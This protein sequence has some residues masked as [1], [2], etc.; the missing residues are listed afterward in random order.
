MP[1]HPRQPEAPRNTFCGQTRRE[2]LWD[3]GGAFTSVALA[4]LL[5]SDGFL[6]GQA[7]AADGTTPLANPLQARPA[8]LPGRAKSVIFLFMYGGPS[9]VDTFDYKPKLYGLDGR[10]I[11]IRT[12]GRGGEKTQGRVVGPK[13]NF[14]PGANA[15]RWSR[16]SSRTSA[17]AWTTSPSSIPCTRSPRC[18][19]RRC[20]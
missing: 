4:G 15:A 8:M 10:T 14:A 13:W 16:N 11:D 6:A 17:S 9:Q 12:K 7:M 19:V 2:F 3:A 18:T 1:N 5:G 20:S